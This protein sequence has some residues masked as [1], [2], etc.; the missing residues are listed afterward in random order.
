MS[1]IL[2]EDNSPIKLLQK[3]TYTIRNFNSTDTKQINS[4]LKNKVDQ[5]SCLFNENVVCYLLRNDGFK[6]F[7]NVFNF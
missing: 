3:K 4:I 5:K 6:I 1:N 7:W 2:G